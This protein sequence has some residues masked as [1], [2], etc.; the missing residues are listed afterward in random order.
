MP[1]AGK[2][3]C[4]WTK[5]LVLIAKAM[6]TPQTT[7]GK[8]VEFVSRLLLAALSEYQGQIACVAR[9]SKAAAISAGS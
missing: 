7:L 3:I 5:Q 8:R 9:T 2:R 1:E 4:A 6:P